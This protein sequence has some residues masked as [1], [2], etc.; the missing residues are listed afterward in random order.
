VPYVTEIAKFPAPISNMTDITNHN[1]LLLGIAFDDAHAVRWATKTDGGLIS[2]LLDIDRDGFSSEGRPL[3]YHFAG[4]QEYLPSIA[5][6]ERS[7][8]K[9]DYP[10]DRLL[11]AIRMPYLRAT[12]TGRVPSTGDCGRGQSAGP[13]AL[14]DHLFQIFPDEKWL[15]DVGSASTPSKKLWLLKTGATTEPEAWKRLLETRPRVFRDAGLAILRTGT[16]PE[17]QIMATLDYGRNVFHAA[18]DRNQVTL[19]AFGKVFTHGPGSL[20]NAGS[21]GM[22]RAT[23]HRLDSFCSHASIGHN[24]ILVDRLDQLQAVG[25]LLAWSPNEQMQAAVSRVDGIRPGVSHTRALVLTQGTVVMLDRVESL[26]EHTYDFVYHNFGSL[27]LGQ[28][29]QAEPAAGPLGATANYENIVDPQ[30]LNGK[31]PIQLNW[32]LTAQDTRRGGTAESH[33]PIG[34]ALWQLPVNGGEVYTGITG[35]NNPDTMV[36]PEAAPTLIHRVRGRS[37]DFC[38]VL[39]PHKGKPRVAYIEAAAGGVTVIW[40]DGQR[41]TLSLDGLIR[42][43]AVPE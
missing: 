36:I 31:G 41:L 39:E 16:T 19:C 10:K 42:Q 8:L 38:T 34:L 12:L 18:L 33:T 23:D 40:T 9:I 13:T 35:L 29:W 20:Y 15:L 32:D 26:Q 11:A 14:A 43:Y 5:Y 22:T 27:S 1:L 30:K 17:S 2:R 6:L 24:L 25:R 3:N 21:G 37:A 7:G 28:G 4:M